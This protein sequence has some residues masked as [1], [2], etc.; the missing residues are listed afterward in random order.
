MHFRLVENKISAGWGE[1]KSALYFADSPGSYFVNW[2]GYGLAFC[3]GI[4]RSLVSADIL[5]LFSQRV[6]SHA[7]ANTL[8][9]AVNPV[10]DVH[11]PLIYHDSNPQ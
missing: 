1:F 9:S 2:F 7:G 8:I 4:S 5:V 6:R 10:A 3:A 11:V